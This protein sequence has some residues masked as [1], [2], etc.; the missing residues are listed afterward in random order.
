IAALVWWQLSEHDGATRRGGGLFPIAV[1]VLLA[2]IGGIALLD[3][4]DVWTVDWRVVLAA[5]AMLTGALVAVGAATGRKVGA[6]VAL[7]VALVLA[8]AL[9]LSVRVPLFTGIG[10]RVVHPASLTALDRTYQLGIGDFNVDL[11]N[12]PLPVGETRV[13]ATLGIGDLTVHVPYGIKVVVDGRASAG[14]V[15][16]F[17]RIAEGRSVHDSASV[18]GGSPRVLVLDARVGL[19]RLEV[20]RG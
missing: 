3:L 12:V 16:V 14:Q 13:K 9:A 15:H 2:S 8:L 6:V 7:D 11:T 5:M 17:G 18:G 4:T 20:R 19:G 10:D 1:G